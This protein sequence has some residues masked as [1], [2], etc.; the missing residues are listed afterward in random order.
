MAENPTQIPEQEERRERRR[1]GAG[2]SESF[3]LKTHT[4][5]VIWK[6]Y[7]EE[8]DGMLSDAQNQIPTLLTAEQFGKFEEAIIK[9]ITDADNEILAGIQTLTSATD[10]KNRKPGDSVKYDEILNVSFEWHSPL[11][12]KYIDAIRH[13]DYLF[14]LIDEAWLQNKI[15]SKQRTEIFRDWKNRFYDISQSLKTLL[16]GAWKEIR[17]AQKKAEEPK[18]K[19]EAPAEE[20]QAPA[21]P[22]PEK[23]EPSQGQATT[24][25]EP[26]AEQAPA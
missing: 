26:V 23:A 2:Q 19:P 16:K 25:S 22:E 6:N 12:R 20:A 18:A 13:A 15:P 4:A 5:R 21:Q 14:V 1:R 11:M 9:T 10:Q 17:D 3:V 8:T 24:V 7:S